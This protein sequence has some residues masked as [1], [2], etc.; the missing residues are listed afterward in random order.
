MN[1]DVYSTQE[2]AR[3]ESQS[4]KCMHAALFGSFTDLTWVDFA[5]G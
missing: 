2:H 1:L 4:S 5:P 3:L